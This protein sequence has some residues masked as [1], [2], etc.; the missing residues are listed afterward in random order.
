MTER[1]VLQFQNGP[2]AKPADNSGDD[3]LHMFKHAENT[4]AANPKTLD[5]PAFSEFSVG[6]GLD[7]LL[8]VWVR[9]SS[10]KEVLL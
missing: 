8:K 3:G 6:T 5:F 2:T 1:K 4:M 9:E 7:A 10:R